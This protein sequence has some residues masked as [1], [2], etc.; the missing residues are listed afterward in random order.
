MCLLQKPSNYY[1]LNYNLF[2][3]VKRD[4]P[5][6]M[7]RRSLDKFYTK[8]HVAIDCIQR[9]L[10]V[11]QPSPEDLIIEPS[12]GNGSFLNHLEQLEQKIDAFDLYPES[13]RIRQQ[14]FYTYVPPQ[15]DASIHVIGNPPFGRQTS[16]ALKFIKKA[17]TFARSISFI[18]PKS[19]KKE[20][21]QRRVPLVFHLVYEMDL[22]TPSFEL[23][24]KDYDVPCIFQ[25]WRRENRFRLDFYE[26]PRCNDFEF[27]NKNQNP[28]IALRRVGVNAGKVSTETLNKT[29]TT[30]YF[31]RFN[32]RS[33][34]HESIQKLEQFTYPSKDYT[35]GPRSISKEEIIKE[36]NASR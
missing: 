6:Q 8:D 18:L 25:I 34:L 1:L 31:L 23:D 7:D 36:W 19:F 13:D 32:D 27:V 33:R 14:D 5:T 21:Y 24:G 11:I 16:G 17:A 9:M 29:V 4:K 15:T 26:R 3:K 12:A 10:D 28:D 35:V 2:S 30:H 20:S 22:P